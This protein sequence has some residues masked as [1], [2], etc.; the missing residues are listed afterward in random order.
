[1]ES[2]SIQGLIST[3][4]LGW[5][6]NHPVL[7]VFPSQKHQLQDTKQQCYKAYSCLHIN[8]DVNVETPA[9]LIRA[10]AMHEMLLEAM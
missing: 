6:S 8:F 7:N 1:M 4:S 3:W 9:T 2:M 10:F 5:H